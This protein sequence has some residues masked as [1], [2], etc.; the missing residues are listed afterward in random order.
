MKNIDVTFQIDED[1]KKQAEALFDDLGMDLSTAFSIFL[2]QSIREQGIPFSV[3]KNTPNE[4]T[5]AAMDAAERGED[6]Y[7]PYDSV[8]NLMEALNA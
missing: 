5:L 2:K 4:V 7:G 3:S 1:I 8:E 6:I